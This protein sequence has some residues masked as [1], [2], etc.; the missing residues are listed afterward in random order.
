MDPK[1]PQVRFAFADGSMTTYNNPAFLLF[2]MATEPAYRLGWAIGESN[3][4]VA[5]IGTGSTSFVPEHA[6]TEMPRSSEQ[7]L[8][9][10]LRQAQVDQ[11]LSCRTIGRCSFGGIIDRELSD[12]TASSPEQTYGPRN[13]AVDTGRAFVY[14]RYDVDLTHAG[15]E[16]L[17][18]G[19]IE[20]DDIASAE[21]VDRLTELEEIG[22]AAGRSVDLIHLAARSLSSASLAA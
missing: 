11:D 2:K 19:H 8:S 1:R 5:S 17:G 7:Q 16:D 10:V 18:L 3:L 22:H 20:P 15:L 21:A 9:A 12:L 13:L 4:L 6:E 14:V